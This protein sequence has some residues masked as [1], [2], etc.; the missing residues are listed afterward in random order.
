MTTAITDATAWDTA[1]LVSSA[2]V[3]C[4][5]GGTSLVNVSANRRPRALVISAVR[6]VTNVFWVLY[7]KLFPSVVLYARAAGRVAFASAHSRVYS[8]TSRYAIMAAYTFILL[9]WCPSSHDLILALLLV[10]YHYSRPYVWPKAS[11][12]AKTPTLLR[13]LRTPRASRPLRSRRAEMVPRL[14]ERATIPTNTSRA[15][16]A[17][18]W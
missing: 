16:S 8:A 9:L 18:S 3:L 1:S 7:L 5:G 13:R 15:E 17:I 11:A 10:D 2:R 4:S 6:T 14:I 12:T